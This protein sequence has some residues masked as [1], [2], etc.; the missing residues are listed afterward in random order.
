M[1]RKKPDRVINTIAIVGSRGFPSRALVEKTLFDLRKRAIKLN[2]RLHIISGGAKGVD[3]WAHEWCLENETQVTI[4]P[5]EW[6]LF[7][8][9]AGY[10]RNEEIWDLSIAGIAFWDGDSPGTQ[11]SFQL[12]EKQGKKCKIIYPPG[13]DP[14][15]ELDLPW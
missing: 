15:K 1:A 2:R 13:W 12:A 3:T 6:S 11:H 7:G 10:L 5:A 9:K 4:I 14:E 8:K